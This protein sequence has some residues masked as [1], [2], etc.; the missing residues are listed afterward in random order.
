MPDHD[1]QLVKVYKFDPYLPENPDIA[2]PKPVK[3][4]CTLSFY[5][6]SLDGPT[7]YTYEVG[8]N[9]NFYAADINSYH[10]VK[11]LLDGDSVSNNRSFSLNM[12]DHDV[13]LV[14]VYKFDPYLPENPK[15]NGLDWYGTDAE[16]VIDD[17]TPGSIGTAARNRLG[18]T[19]ASS[20]KSIVVAGKAHEWDF[21]LID[22]FSAC[23]WY[24][25]S[26]TNLVYIQNYCSYNTVLTHLF[27]PQTVEEIASYAFSGCTS[28]N[29]LTCLATTPPTLGTNVFQ[30]VPEDMTVYVHYASIPLYQAA[31]GW[32]NFTI[33]PLREEVR[34]L[35]IH[36][37]EGSED[38]RC[39]NMT[40]EIVNAKSGV[41]NRYVVSDRITYVFEML[42]RCTYNIYLRNHHGVIMSE[43][44]DVDVINDPVSVTFGPLKPIY[45]VKLRVETPD[46][47]DVTDQTAV[48][49]LDK[50]GE[51]MGQD[52]TLDGMTE[53]TTLIVQLTL[54]DDLGADFMAPAEFEY[55]VVDGVNNP[56][57]TLQP[58][59]MHKVRGL[60]VDAEDG[61]P[62]ANAAII[63][64]QTMN[65]K[66][67]RSRTTSAGTTGWYEMDLANVPTT[68]TASCDGHVS[69]TVK[70][71]SITTAV[72]DTMKLEPIVTAYI[73]V[74]TNHTDVVLPGEE[75]VTLSGYNDRDDLWFEVRD[76]TRD[77]LLTG[78][79]QQLPLL[80]MPPVVEEG[81]ELDI[82]CHSHDGKFAPIHATVTV[83]EGMF[84]VAEFTIIP[85]GRMEA[86]FHSTNNTAVHGS[87]YAADGKLSRTD[88][89]DET[90]LT[91][92]NLPDGEYT[93]VSMGT[94]TYYNTIYQ[95]SELHALGL[96]EGIDYVSQ[97][98]K[99]ESG[100]VTVVEIDHVPTFVDS[101]LY[102]TGEKTSFKAGA[103]KVKQGK[104]VTYTTCIDFKKLYEGKVSNVRLLYEFSPMA[105]FVNGS[106]VKNNHVDEYLAGDG[107]LTVQGVESG[108]VVKFCLKPEGDGKL[109]ATAMVE[110][111]NEG[112]TIRQPIGMAEVEVASMELRIPKKTAFTY[113]DVG[114]DD[115]PEGKYRSLEIYDNGHLMAKI[116][117]IK[118][119]YW[120][121]YFSPVGSVNAKR[122]ISRNGLTLK[123]DDDE[124]TYVGYVHCDLYEPYY[125]S[126]H[127]IQ[128][129]LIGYDGKEY[130]TKTSS[131]QYDP[132]YLHIGAY[133]LLPSNDKIIISYDDRSINKNR[134]F[135]P[136]LTSSKAVYVPIKFYAY[137]YPNPNLTYLVEHLYFEYHYYNKD[138]KRCFGIREGYWGDPTI[139]SYSFSDFFKTTY[140]PINM[141]V[142][143]KQR[144]VD[145]PPDKAGYNN[146]FKQLKAFIATNDSLINVVNTLSE[147][148][149]AEL[150][151]TSPN[152][153]Y[154]S[155][156]LSEQTITADKLWEGH[157]VTLTAQDYNNI[158]AFVNAAS[159]V[160][161]RA[162]W[163][164]MKT[165]INTLPEYPQFQEQNNAYYTPSMTFP[166]ADLGNGVFTPSMT[167][168]IGNP[169]TGNFLEDF[170]A[171]NWHLDEATMNGS[172]DI[173]SF[174]NDGGDHL[175]L[176]F[177]GQLP[178]FSPNSPYIAALLSF[179]DGQIQN[180][181]IDG[182]MAMFQDPLSM[183][184]YEGLIKNQMLA[185][186]IMERCPNSAIAKM[187]LEE[188]NV[189]KA[190][191]MFK[192]GAQ[193]AANL[194]KIGKGLGSLLSIYDI[195]KSWGEVDDDWDM[196]EYLFDQAAYACKS[197]VDDGGA[198]QR[199]QSQRDE[200]RRKRAW[201]IGGKGA[202][203]AIGTAVG[204]GG[205]V[206]KVVSG[207]GIGAGTGLAGYEQQL[208]NEN[209][210]NM[211]DFVDAIN[212]TPGCSKIALK[213]PITDDFFPYGLI[214]PSGYVYE[215]VSSN[216]LEGVTTTI[217]YKDSIQDAYGDWHN[218]V[219]LWDAEMYD[220]QNPMYSDKNGKYGWDV[221]EGWWQVKYEKEG[222]ETTYSEWLPVPPPQLDVNIGMVQRTVPE[223]KFAKAYLDG[224]EVTFDKY[225]DLETINTDNIHV[226]V[227][228]GE[229][230][231]LL[232][233]CTITLLNEESVTKGDSLS[234]A[235]K[236]RISPS[237]G[238]NGA[239]EVVL[240]VSRQ[241][242]SYAGVKMQEDFIQY[243]DIDLR[244]REIVADTMV[245]MVVDST[246]TM[247]VGALPA[248][249]SKGK[250]LNITCSSEGVLELTEQQVTL[251]ENGEALIRMKG[252]MEGGILVN[253]AIEGEEAEGETAVR[254]LSVADL[255]VGRPYASRI[256]GTE[257]YRG[258]TV[259]L[260]SDTEGATIY[261]TT[262][263]SC[264]CEDTSSRHLYDGTPIVIDQP[265]VIRAIAVKDGWFDSDATVLHYGIRQAD[266]DIALGSGWN[267]ISH[268]LMDDVDVTTLKGKASRVVSQVN[269]VVDDPVYGFV[270]NLKQMNA[271]ECY[272]VNAPTSATLTLQGD[273]VDGGNMQIPLVEGWN[274][275][276][277]PIGQVMSV[278]EAL[279]PTDAD[280]ED[281][282][283]G[284]EGFATFEDGMW[285]GTLNTLAPGK[286]YLYKSRSN[287]VLI[288]DNSIVSVAAAHNR[289][290]VPL[291]P[292]PWAVDRTKYPNTMNIIAQLYDDDIPVGEGEYHIGAFCDTECRG[293]GVYVNGMLYLTIYGN[294]GETIHFQ[295]ADCDNDKLHGVMET[296]DFE[297]DVLGS[298]HQPVALHIGSPTKVRAA[299]GE[300]PKVWPRSTTDKLNVSFTNHNLQSLTLTSAGGETMMRQKADGD[301]IT[302][303]I[304]S[305]PKGIYILTVEAGG[306]SYY[307]KVVRK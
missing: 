81:D 96:Q 73:M 250:V 75:A 239:D 5:P 218:T 28:L 27:L 182:L 289:H 133:G 107:M 211:R 282:I 173:I 4:L 30:G 12:P 229:E 138:G 205:K 192:P 299:K 66:Y 102:Y 175:N 158:N 129:K 215:A 109:M 90:K 45:D 94:S 104:T 174:V 189:D 244:V 95:L 212:N 77:S 185:K 287:N 284:Q 120:C 152:Y 234:Y 112:R 303:H 228:N 35:E 18:D 265:I 51:Y 93:L 70:L 187:M 20:I 124:E 100:K 300:Q 144:K 221:P 59:E 37:P 283:V 63:A 17:F 118:T 262:D 235:S 295:A 43:V 14:K 161:R 219:V 32:G 98:L 231:T 53:G 136:E 275:V 208:K 297:A 272:K 47:E 163:E 217:Y 190:I 236:L 42:R 196:W 256:S 180:A 181:L 224:V 237:N 304:G 154:V 159:D 33:L 39:K 137:F 134:Y 146:Y 44:K 61:M 54:S 122:K 111:D 130:Y 88:E 155:T 184:M 1:V 260:E 65:G 85:Y 269:E 178:D 183:K 270:G 79:S 193:V 21:G 268:R 31:E 115:I 280:E 210:Q 242:K 151:K 263:G 101:H 13:Q 55:K 126:Y 48:T 80:V 169:A 203:G 274:W 306:K 92:D 40:M 142:D 281:A 225:M 160:E 278:K 91:F 222:Y 7:T 145:L 157:S 188:A 132:T 233:D 60:V 140:L 220:Q 38:G 119:G 294:G 108:D 135:V 171:T 206:A 238:W 128:A 123:Y 164:N 195:L 302:L 113:V 25:F 254:V 117:S 69:K 285:S 305:M 8:T 64:T 191:F 230:E 97:S 240:I 83:G 216:R 226:K 153:D 10:F 266:M 16:L 167:Y 253:M 36:L 179:I 22:S 245:M 29:Y 204:G 199:A 84:G 198:H 232:D 186:A 279:W 147:Q 106:V 74:K 177:N 201:V 252:L 67:R 2:E 82:T 307:Y 273:E 76:V 241:V 156:L 131:C 86:T 103:T 127:G 121:L 116:D 276:G 87:L 197:G 246:A 290:N 267:W 150:A 271:A 286:G 194:E 6:E 72:L 227:V 23:E 99:M 176:D 214:D 125:Y 170:S 49:W 243:L 148:I 172:P 301:E 9:H 71:D 89:Y 213:K 149:N 139:Y 166:P 78:V 52:F 298:R 251:D 291:N 202:I 58:F 209:M 19:P 11:W 110:F 261:Y 255:T 257:V 292:A 68:L 288:Y 62:L 57:F 3:H 50:Y 296:F 264:P 114:L 15:P 143:V 200:Y 165:N 258:Q 249:A 162:I 259:T 168:E 277:Y 105:R 34:N 46:G 247:R 248:D 41:K 293:I 207:L 26:R 24:D 223:V 141:S 56:V